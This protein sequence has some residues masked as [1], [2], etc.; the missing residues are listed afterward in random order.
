MIDMLMVLCNEVWD[1]NASGP[2]TRSSLSWVCPI[3][4][5]LFGRQLAFE[6]IEHLQ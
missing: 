2:V 5:G 1:S 6:I 4:L 3:C